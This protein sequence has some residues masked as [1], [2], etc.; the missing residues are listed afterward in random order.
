MDNMF[1][2]FEQS[3]TVENS[4]NILPVRTIPESRVSSRVCVGLLF[5]AILFIPFYN[6]IAPI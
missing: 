4:P 6:A 5:I 1:K 2:G 3:S